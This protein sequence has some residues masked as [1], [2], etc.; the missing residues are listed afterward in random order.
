MPTAEELIVAIKSEGVGETQ[1]DLE[2]VESSMEDTA[3][4]AGDSADQLEGFSERFAGAMGAAVAALAVGAAGLLAQVPVLGEAFSGLAAIVDAVSFQMDSVLRPAMSDVTD[5]L[6]EIANAIF[7]AD[8]SLADLIGTLGTLGGVAGL[9]AGAMLALGIS[10]TGPV[11]IALATITAAVAAFAVMWETNFGNI[12]SIAMNAFRRIQSRIQRF[13]NVVQPIINDFITFTSALWDK[14]GDDIMSVVRLAFRTSFA[15]ISTILD[16]ILTTVQVALQVLS[17]DWEGAFNS[18]VNFLRRNTARWEPII[19]DAVGGIMDVFTGLASDI[20]SWAD[21]LADN[22]AQWGKDLIDS[23]ISGIESKIQDLRDIL[24][25]FED[26]AAVVGVDVPEF[27]GFGGG[28]GSGL[29]SESGGR[30]GG[31]GGRFAPRNTRTG[32]TRIDG[33]QLT[34]STGRYRSDP[35]RRRGL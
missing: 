32:G 4:A 34:E 8:G 31:G 11:G 6:F 27:D 26:I 5:T 18:I 9:V 3:D 7:E 21:G 14:Y 35:G 23:F 25:E 19:S 30:G 16:T 24:S 10:L 28:G 13:V 1:E 2:G 12:R 20:V 17:G 29:G 15:I 22:A 33:R